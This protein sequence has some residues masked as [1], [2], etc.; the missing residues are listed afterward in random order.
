MAMNY[1]FSFFLLM[2]SSRT[3]ARLGPRNADFGVVASGG[4]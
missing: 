1:A 3:L 4:I 2:A